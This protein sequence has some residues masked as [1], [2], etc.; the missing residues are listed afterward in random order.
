[1]T[2]FFSEAVFIFIFFSS[3]KCAISTRVKINS[4]RLSEGELVCG[5][6]AI[7]L[8]LSINNSISNVIMYWFPL[9]RGEYIHELDLFKGPLEF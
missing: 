5:Q 4:A 2:T 6:E 1:M 8:T 7:F 3:S 9:N